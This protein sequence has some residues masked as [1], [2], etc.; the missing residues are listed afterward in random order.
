MGVNWYNLKVFQFIHNIIGANT[1]EKKESR[2][3]SDSLVL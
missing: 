3:Q 1:E 2:D